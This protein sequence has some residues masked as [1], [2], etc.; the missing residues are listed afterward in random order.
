LPL[1]GG[2][3]RIRA[4]WLAIIGVAAVAI[5]ASIAGW[6]NQLVQDD[7]SL[8]LQNTRIHQLSNWREVVTSPYW[9]AAWNPEL[10]RPVTSLLHAA[11]FDLGGARPVVFR[12]LSYLLY[13]GSAVGVYFLAA[14]LLPWFV[15][16]C[17]AMLF[18]AH[19]VHVE[20]V[21]LGVGQSELLVGL[22]AL[23]MTSH[24]IL[25]RLRGALRSRDWAWLLVL[26]VLAS[27]TKEQGTLLPALLIAAEVLLFPGPARPRV[28]RLWRGYAMLAGVAISIVL[29]RRSILAGQFAGAAVAEALED[30]AS[31]DGC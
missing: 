22:F 14:R 6:S 25:A 28:R 8:I 31:A 5:A 16:L 13:A 23:A 1:E 17:V 7:V 10:Y 11:Q 27:L 30:W 2:T 15:A 21:A 9:P 4:P 26:Y 24:Y 12:A 18:A 3:G 19:P 29:W 20:A